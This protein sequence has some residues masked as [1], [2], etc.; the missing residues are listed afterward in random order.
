MTEPFDKQ[1]GRREW[2]P[3]DRWYSVS[4]HEFRDSR[5][6]R[7][8]LALNPSYDIR[9]H[10][11]PGV[12]INTRGYAGSDVP[13]PRTSGK[14]GVLKNPDLNFGVLL[15]DDVKPT[16]RQASYFPWSSAEGYVDRLGDYTAAG[17]LTRDRTNGLTLDS[18]Q[19]SSDSQRG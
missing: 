15:D 16:D 3:Q 8:L 1:V 7:Y 10:P 12:P 4:Y 19:A 13:N 11:A 18:P 9:Y 6:W 14:G 2:R 17:M 5:E